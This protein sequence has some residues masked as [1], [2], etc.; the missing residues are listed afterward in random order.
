[1]TGF[2]NP[3]TGIQ[4]AKASLGGDYLDAGEGLVEIDAIKFVV[5]ENPKTKGEPLHIATFQVWLWNPVTGTKEVLPGSKRSW[6]NN[7][8]KT[9]GLGNAKLFLCAMLD[10]TEEAFEALP[11]VAG[12][13]GLPVSQQ[14]QLSASMIAKEQPFKGTI[15]HV[16]TKVIQTRNNTDF[17][18][19]TWR[20][21]TPTELAKVEAAKAKYAASMP[22]EAQPF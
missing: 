3:F 20:W 12:P 6:V 5:S 17:T 11:P 13:N 2:V 9:P 16:E 14:D 10:M 7:L 1:M 18:K 21:P 19:H 15:L 8:K 4:H 22:A